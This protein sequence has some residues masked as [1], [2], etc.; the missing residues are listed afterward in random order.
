MKSRIIVASLAVVLGMATS[1]IADQAAPD[2]Q[3]GQG[4]TGVTHPQDVIAA[5]VAL[6]VEIERLMQPLDT[7]T[8]DGKG[9]PAALDSAALTISQMLLALPHLF[10]P[11]TNLYDPKVVTPATIALP[12]IWQDFATF[13][14]LAA[15]ASNAAKLLST[16]TDAAGIKAGSLALRATCDA[17]HTVFLRPFVEQKPNA[18][19]AAFDFDS[20]FE[21]ADKK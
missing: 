2:K 18:A 12:A 14:S 4:W 9:D 17:C 11:T 15:A 20:V 8:V 19:D 3:Q 13:Y 7:Y 6:M 5:R 16:K 10:P 21:K 1:A